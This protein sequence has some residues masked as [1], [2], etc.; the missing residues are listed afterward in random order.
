MIMEKIDVLSAIED[1]KKV[2]AKYWRLI[3]LKEFDRL[4]EVFSQDAVFDAREATYDPVQGLIPGTSFSDVWQ[5]QR[6]IIEGIKMAMPAEMQSV[7]M[8]HIPEITVESVDRAIAI[9][10]FNDRIILPEKLRFNG[11]GYYH[12]VYTKKANRWMIESSKIQRL[13]ICVE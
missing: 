7:H 13:L 4:E 8:G 1:I 11:F 10:P 6:G 3:D 12:E 5:T 9:F 2:K